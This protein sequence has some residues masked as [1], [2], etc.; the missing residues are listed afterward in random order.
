MNI[1]HRT[2]QSKSCPCLWG[3]AAFSLMACLHVRDRTRERE[4]ERVCVCVR[5]CVCVFVAVGGSMNSDESDESHLLCI[6]PIKR[7]LFPD[8]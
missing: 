6:Q 1:P 8:L 5:A 7:D 2:L 3:K 4:R